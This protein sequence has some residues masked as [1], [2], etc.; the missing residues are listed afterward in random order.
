[1]AYR[2]YDEFED[3][4]KTEDGNFIVEIDLPDNQWILYYISTLGPY[5]E[6]LEPK[7][8]REKLKQQLQ[9]TL[10]LYK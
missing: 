3:Y 7:E 6:V 1:M 2:V 10:N 9:E 4:K 8:V 5:C